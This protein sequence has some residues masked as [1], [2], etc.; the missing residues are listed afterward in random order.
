M[1]LANP[2]TSHR[3]SNTF[4]DH[5]KTRL[6]REPQSVLLTFCNAIRT[7]ELSE[8]HSQF[9]CRLLAARLN[10]VRGLH[11][12]SAWSFVRQCHANGSCTASPC[13]SRMALG[14]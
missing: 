13:A 1:L 11:M 10:I 6:L 5:I 8:C 14:W 4:A 12:W 2:I 9:N 3:D 7:S